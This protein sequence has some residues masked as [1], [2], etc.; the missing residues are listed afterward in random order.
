MNTRKP[1]D[2]IVIGWREWVALPDL[3]VRA[4]KA[5][6]DT[7]ARTSSLHAFDLE[8]FRED[9]LDMVRFKIHPE[10]RSSKREKTVKAP[11]HEWRNVRSS[12]GEAELRP[13]ILTTIEIF[14]ESWEVELTLT[15]RDTMG[16]RMLLGRQAVRG[17]IVVDPGRSFLN[18]PR[19]K[20]TGRILTRKKSPKKP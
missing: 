10:Q 12:S 15:R 13:V 8:P 14:G 20:R 16:F 4:I 2:R 5:K 9:S 7:G 18:G 11:V 17:H 1:K 6:V 3:G 19:G